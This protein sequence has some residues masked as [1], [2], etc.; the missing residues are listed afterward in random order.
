M[1]GCTKKREDGAGWAGRICE[2][3]GKGDMVEN[4]WWK[5][6]EGRGLGKGHGGGVGE[7][8]GRGGRPWRGFKSKEGSGVD[9]SRREQLALRAS[10]SLALT[11]PS[12][13]GVSQPFASLRPIAYGI[14]DRRIA[15]CLFWTR[16]VAA[17]CVIASLAC[18]GSRVPAP[19]RRHR[20]PS[21]EHSP[22]PMATSLRLPHSPLHTSSPNV[23]SP[24]ISI[25]SPPPPLYS[26]TRP[27]PTRNKFLPQASLIFQHASFRPPYHHFLQLVPRPLLSQRP[28]CSS[29]QISVPP[30][31]SPFTR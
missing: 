3:E 9:E 20:R 15:S 10:C 11:T 23:H 21:R 13:V 5:G 16:P 24:F 31:A 12:A 2:S 25:T 18:P 19:A 27:H 26:F 4:V 1:R 8:R 22:F 30:R 17:R 7:T 29:L 14:A 28:S 6:G